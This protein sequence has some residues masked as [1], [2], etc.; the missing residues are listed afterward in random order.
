[1]ASVK[2]RI[3]TDGLH[4]AVQT[5]GRGPEVVF[6]HGLTA[7]RS[8]IRRKL[9]PLARHYRVVSFDQR[10]HGDSA[11]V[12]DARLFALERMAADIGRV[13]D[14]LGLGSAVVGGESMGA[15]TALAFALRNPGRVKALLLTAPASLALACRT[16]IHWVV[17]EDMQALGSLSFPVCILCWPDDP[18]HPQELAERM[19]AALPR[20]RLIKLPSIAEFFMDPACVGRHYLRFLSDIG[21]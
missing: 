3:E 2:R 11:A 9:Q 21:L 5:H 1:M 8:V 16:V 7:N 4:L 17:L 12:Q 15:A 20:T 18:L 10:G 13:L 14:S 19:A 6:A